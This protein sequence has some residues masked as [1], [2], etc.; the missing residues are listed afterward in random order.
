MTLDKLQLCQR[1]LGTDYTGQTALRTAVINACRGAPEL[2]MALFKPA[3]ECEVPFSDLRSSVETY[4]SRETSKKFL[5]AA[6]SGDDQFYTNRRYRVN[7]RG[8]SRG[9]VPR[10]QCVNNRGPPHSNNRHHWRKKCF[11]CN[12]KGC[13]ST[14]H[15]Q[16]ERRQAR[17]QYVSHCEFTGEDPRS[18]ATYLAEYEGHDLDQEDC[19][20]DN[21]DEGEL[22]GA[23][24]THYL[25]DQAFLYR[26]TGEDIYNTAPDT[27][28]D[29]FTLTGR[30]SKMKFQGILPDTG[31][32]QVSTAGHEQFRALKIEDPLVQ[33][34]NAAAGKAIVRF[35]KGTSVA[36]IGSLMLKTPIGTINF[37]VL[38]TPTPFLLCLADM[39]RLGV[40][41]DNTTNQLVNR[42][43]KTAIPVVRKWGHPWFFLSRKEAAGMFLT[44]TELRRLHCRFGHP[45]TDRL[46]TLLMRAGHEDVDS[47]V[48]KG[49]EKFCHSC[50]MNSQSPRRFKF[51]LPEDCEFSYEIIVDVMYL[52]NRPVL[53]V[54]DVATAFQAGKF[55][56]SLS[57]KETW[58][59]LRFLWIDTY[60]GPSDIVTHDAGTNFASHE[61]RNEAKMM[62]ITCKQIPIEAHW[63]IG[64]LD[65][66][67]APLR[68]AYE[69]INSEL[70]SVVSQDAILQMAFKAVNDTTGPNGLVPTLLVF[71]T[72]PRINNESPPPPSLLK[73]ADAIQK[74][75]KSLRKAQAKR[76][77]NNAINTRNGPSVNEIQSLP[78]QSE[79]C[80]WR[81]KDGWQGPFKII[82]TDRHNVTVD[83]VNGPVAFRSTVVKPYYRDPDTSF[84]P[85]RLDQDEDEDD[86]I[87]ANVY[88]APPA[89]QP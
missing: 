60:Q 83:M 48:L 18:F 61:F 42:K 4:V 69:V 57:A 1:A 15:T 51:T 12:R 79:V 70:N 8:S 89:L 73:R 5:T 36:S 41:F 65:R 53:H 72:Y 75:M 6:D 59:V 33:L 28:A 52:S 11:V 82:A 37:H 17:S 34:D 87:V 35:G 38:D 31:A 74:A 71:S 7:D 10:G 62:G 84:D 58:E 86:L 9:R 22:N 56:P 49:I 27:S 32:A 30:Y 14:K 55:L 47:S 54:V 81:E 19:C 46:H 24:T 25:M 40:Y 39:D 43:T 80:V 77:I 64:K 63:S 85:P 21:S 3:L 68:R 2:E 13:W 66:Y 26:I 44:E 16:E 67:H 76:Q 88:P 50:Q 29:Q 23:S 20:N 78:L 45:A